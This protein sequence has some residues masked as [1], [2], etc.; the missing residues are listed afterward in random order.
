MRWLGARKMEALLYVHMHKLYTEVQFGYVN[1]QVHCN[2]L[3]NIIVQALYK[4][5]QCTLKTGLW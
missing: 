2:P 5:L 4:H 1:A 3:H